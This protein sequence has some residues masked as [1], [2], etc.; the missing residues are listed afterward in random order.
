MAAPSRIHVGGFDYELDFHDKTQ[1]E[2]FREIL[3]GLGAADGK[4]IEVPIFDEGR[5]P[6]M[7][8]LNPRYVGPVV[9][10]RGLQA[11][12]GEIS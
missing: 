10:D 7:L 3:D 9:L 1:E 4:V 11:R 5:R 8:Y 6:M 12:P 2:V